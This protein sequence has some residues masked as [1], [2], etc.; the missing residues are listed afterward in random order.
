MI[1]LEKTFVVSLDVDTERRA[2]IRR[3]LPSRG[4]VDFEFVSAIPHTDEIVQRYYE[5]GS[6]QEYPACFRCHQLECECANNV[7]IPQQVANWLSFIKV[8][9]ICSAFPDKFFLICEDDVSF[10]EGSERVLRAFFET[11]E[12]R[13]ENVLVRMAASGNDPTVVLGQSGLSV[14]NRVV[15]S[16]A[17]YII[18]GHMA[19]L[20]LSAFDRIE[21]TSD[22]WLH[23]DMANR[24]D[25]TAM[26][27]EPLLATDLS[28]NQE[29][30]RF[31][32]R[33]HPKGI[34]ANDQKKQEEHIKRVGSIDEYR[35]LRDEWFGS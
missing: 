18:N 9:K 32:S 7:I 33:I 2:H 4:L 17:A 26:T 1:D 20:L 12:P 25:V 16:N 21:T 31:A 8:W 11:F 34:D 23:R 30:A 22:I 27:I 15:M 19:R 13:P 5:N 3:H 35:R 24:S 29:F 6:V 28:F 10:F 14:S